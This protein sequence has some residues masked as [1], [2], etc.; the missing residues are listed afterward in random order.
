V[1]SKKCGKCGKCGRGLMIWHLP[2]GSEK[3]YETFEPV[4]EIR[5]EPRVSRIK[6]GNISS[7]TTLEK[8]CPYLEPKK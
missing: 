8:D 7:D 3:Y 6:T 2:A 1:N 4:Y 5:S